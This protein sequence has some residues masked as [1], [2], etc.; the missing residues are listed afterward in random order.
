M[1]KPALDNPVVIGK[2]TGVHGVAGWLKVMPYTQDILSV[3]AYQ[4]WYVEL[5]GR[6]IPLTVTA[7]K[8]YKNVG[9]IVHL[10]SFDDCNTAKRFVNHIFSVDRSSFPVLADG[11]YW[12]DLLG[13]RVLT[14]GDQDLGN[15]L[16]II[17]TP[18]QT[19]LIVGPQHELI[20]YVVGPIVKE[21]NLDEG[22]IRIDWEG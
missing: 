9:L 20:P 7:Y 12:V 15:I 3:L 19:V 1:V 21:V 13:L 5:D 18:A 22:F 8:P 2:F 6:L 10:D 17:E 14:L 16:D 4:P 11:H